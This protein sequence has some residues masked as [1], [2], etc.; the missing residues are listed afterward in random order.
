MDHDVS[1]MGWGRE[2]GVGE[3]GG[4]GGGAGG[5]KEKMYDYCVMLG[6][7]FSCIWVRPSKPSQPC[8]R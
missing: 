6:D 4:G 3:G 1:G 8:T 7:V 5:M 2:G